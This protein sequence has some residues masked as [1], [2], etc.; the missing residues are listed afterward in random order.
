MTCAFTRRFGT[1]FACDLD[2]GFLER[3]REAV[4]RFGKVDRLRTVEVAD[5]RTPAPSPTTPPTSRS[6]TSRCSTASATTP[7]AL[8]DEALR[9]VRPGGQ[10]ALNFRSWSGVDPFVLP[11]GAADAGAVPGA[12]HRA[13]AVAQAAA[14][15]PRLAGQPPRPAPGARARSR[16]ALTD[17]VDLAQPGARRPA[18]GRQATPR[19]STSTASTATTGGS[20]PRVR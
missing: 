18:L 7:L 14:D 1:V 17:V 15:P 2:A 16:T 3:C 8:V 4:A 13:V 5:G 10:I 9:V 20:S 11:V 6:A 12:R 19:R